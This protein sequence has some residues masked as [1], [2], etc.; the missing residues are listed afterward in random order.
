MLR[1]AGALVTDDSIVPFDEY[2]DDLASRR[3]ALA[4][5]GWGNLCH[6]EIEAF[7]MGTPVLMPRLHN[8]LHNELVP[9]EHYVSVDVDSLSAP[10][11]DVARAILERWREVKDDDAF[12]QAVARNAMK[13]YDENAAV[14]ACYRLTAALLQLHP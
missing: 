9:D 2:C 11:E 10:P 7:G 4:L 5:P 14:P 6:R 1:A 12:L 3:L 8:R 13:W